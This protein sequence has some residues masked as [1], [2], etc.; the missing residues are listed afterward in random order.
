MAKAKDGPVAAT[1]AA[2]AAPEE[3]LSPIKMFV[4]NTI[5]NL[6]KKSEIVE[7]LQAFIL[8]AEKN[9]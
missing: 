8:E 4:R 6:P 1:V 5:E 9:I 2:V 7:T 3:M